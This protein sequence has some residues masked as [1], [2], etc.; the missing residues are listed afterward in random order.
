MTDDGKLI[1]RIK[2]LCWPTRFVFFCSSR[3]AV[4]SSRN[5]TPRLD[6][7]SR[8]ASLTASAAAIFSPP[9]S[10]EKDLRTSASC[11]MMS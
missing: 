2:G 4:G 9:E 11:T 5:A 1:E 8:I 10:V 7:C 3:F 6:S